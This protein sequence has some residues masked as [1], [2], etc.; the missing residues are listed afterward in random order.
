AFPCLAGL[1][2]DGAFEDALQ[3]PPYVASTIRIALARK[4]TGRHSRRTS[5]EV[6]RKH[7]TTTATAIAKRT[8]GSRVDCMDSDYLVRRR[9]SAIQRERS[10]TICCARCSQRCF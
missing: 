10:F 8:S 6:P 7:A 5:A 9:C 2:F 4:G 3:L 1:E